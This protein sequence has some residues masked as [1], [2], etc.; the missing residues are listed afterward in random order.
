MQKPKI[1]EQHL[2]VLR[3]RAAMRAVHQGI[4]QAEQAGNI[5]RKRDLETKLRFMRS[6][7]SECFR[8]LRKAGWK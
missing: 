4:R 2:M 1:A 3:Q 5:F 8:N 6:E 7:L